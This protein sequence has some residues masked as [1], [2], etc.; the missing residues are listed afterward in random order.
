MTTLGYARQL[1]QRNLATL[2]HSKLELGN[3]DWDE[4]NF[5]VKR[6][7]MATPTK[8]ENIDI[9]QRIFYHEFRGGTSLPYKLVKPP[10]SKT[11]QV[12]HANSVFDELELVMD[13]NT[14]SK[15]SH[16]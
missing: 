6:T 9:H 16:G 12:F 11:Q 4:T 2:K 1:P 8:S 3:S 15:S 13:I 7:T 10:N 14:S 5:V